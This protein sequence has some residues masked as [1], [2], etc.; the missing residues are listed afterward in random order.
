M[1]SVSAA[2]VG[3]HSVGVVAVSDPVV[4]NS[5]L[6]VVYFPGMDRTG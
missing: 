3:R 4:K 2:A 5:V 1:S 6:R